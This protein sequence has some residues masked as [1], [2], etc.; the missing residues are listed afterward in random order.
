[1]TAIRVLLV[2]D[3]PGDARLVEEYLAESLPQR[4]EVEHLTRLE[5]ALERAALQAWEVILLDLSL[6]DAQ[7][8]D[9][10]RLML[11]AFPDTPVVVMS[12]YSEVEL[13]QRF[14]HAAPRAFLQKPFTRTS[15]M[16]RLAAVLDRP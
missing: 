12:G 13:T 11:A 2:E 9:T 15:L 7:G 10:V 16:A 14:A 6:P 3:N 1:M 8:L 5:P 4:F